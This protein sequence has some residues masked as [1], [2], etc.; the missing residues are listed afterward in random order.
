MIDRRWHSSIIDVRS[1]RGADC[2]TDHYLVVAKVRERLAV[3]KQAAQKFEGGRF[4][5]RK[6]NDL[7]FRKQYQIEITNR[8][9]ALE[10]VSDDEDINRGWKSIKKNIKPQLQRV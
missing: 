1:F 3:R 4:N 9:A 8:F 6:L 2:D 5:L 7:E 10:N